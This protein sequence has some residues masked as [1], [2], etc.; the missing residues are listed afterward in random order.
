MFEKSELIGNQNNNSDNINE[1]PVKDKFYINDEDQKILFH[2]ETLLPDTSS[3]N[4]IYMHTLDWALNNKDIKNLAITGTYGSGKSSVLKSFWSNFNGKKKVLE[5]SAATF[6]DMEELDLKEGSLNNTITQNKV[7]NMLEH[8]IMQQM[9]YKVK[10]Q[11]I[12]DSRFN[13]IQS[14]SVFQ[15]IIDFIIIFIALFIIFLSLKYELYIDLYKNI[16]N[17]GLNTTQTVYLIL[18]LLFTLFTIYRI[19]TVTKSFKIKSLGVGKSS[20]ELNTEGTNTVFN[21]YLDEIIYFFKKNDYSIVVFEDLDRFDNLNIFERLRGLNQLLNQSEELNEKSIVFIYALKDDIFSSDDRIE[22]IQ[23]RTKFFDFIIPMVKIM[24]SSNS[25]SIL[26][27]K[28]DNFLKHEESDSD[29][30]SKKL[31]TDVSFFISDMRVLKNIC[32]EYLIF[33]SALNN[34]GIVQNKLFAI[35]VYKNIYPKDYSEL[36][37][38]KGNLVNVFKSKNIILKKIL[39]IKKAEVEKKTK[40]LYEIENEFLDE[41]D[42]LAMVYLRKVEFLNTSNEIQL[43]NKIFKMSSKSEMI[44]FMNLVQQLDPLSEQ[45]I[46]NRQNGMNLPLKK[47]LTANGKAISIQKRIEFIKSKNDSVVDELNT[48]IDKLQR[49]MKEIYSYSF[50]EFLKHTP[51]DEAKEIETILKDMELLNVLLLQGWIDENYEEYVTYFYEGAMSLEDLDFLKKVRLNQKANFNFG[52]K[53]VKEV[54]KKLEK[55]H[56]ETEAILNFHLLS[57]LLKRNINEEVLMK[58][59][60]FLEFLSNNLITNKVVREFIIGFI[61]YCDTEDLLSEEKMFLNELASLN[62][63]LWTSIESELQSKTKTKQFFLK[64][65]DNIPTDLIVK[66]DYNDNIKNFIEE[67]ADFLFWWEGSEI[68]SNENK[69]KLSELLSGLNVKFTTL[70]SRNNSKLLIESL[71]EADAYEITNST[72]QTFVTHAENSSSNIDYKSILLHPS[73]NL[74]E[75]IEEN[76]NQFVEDVLLI[77][78][79]YVEEEEQVIKLL[80]NDKIFNGLKINILEKWNGQITLL[81][82]LEVDLEVYLKIIELK[83]IKNTWENFLHFYTNVGDHE[84]HYYMDEYIDSL[85]NP[86]RLSDTFNVFIQDLGQKELK[87]SEENGLNNLLVAIANSNIFSIYQ[88]TTFFNDLLHNLEN[89]T[90]KSTFNLLVKSN[91]LPWNVDYYNFFKINDEPTIGEQYLINFVDDNFV[92]KVISLEEDLN[93]FAKIIESS[94]ID[95]KIKLELLFTSLENGRVLNSTIILWYLNEFRKTDFS[96]EDFNLQYTDIENLLTVSELSQEDRALIFMAILESNIFEK[97]SLIKALKVMPKPF[98]EL[99]IIR[100]RNIVF[101]N[102]EM[103]LNLMNMLSER[104]LIASFKVLDSDIVVNSKNKFF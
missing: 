22:E 57:Y 6:I 9:F 64:L 8:N 28:L 49:E 2:F 21:K 18:F 86:D 76:I 20:I 83:R 23:N 59:Q 10:P 37:Y 52:L 48:S 14:K 34:S 35:I 65:F 67:D 89:E 93:L 58:K 44:E 94:D 91:L 92:D 41:L 40:L 32:N 103:L 100:N 97:E 17:F 63:K 72:I 13:R 30:I 78:E 75:R 69:I 25:E 39:E 51:I 4:T 16:T 45:N 87:P 68:F 31:I 88:L 3:N 102:N 46:R 42:E 54:Q 74:R 60:F 15:T 70:N 43:N 62:Y 11:R 73:E 50:S 71:I 80:N 77:H 5:I 27:N 53:Y 7:V 82:S 66:M 1:S 55:E 96:F 12:P 24:H 47:F 104:K 36:L 84:Y 101:E 38:G 26:L 79:T 29:G 33:R 56:F 19:I 85:D 61:D 90:V 81:D 95:L 99:T 98:S